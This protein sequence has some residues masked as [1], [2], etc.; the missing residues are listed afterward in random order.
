MPS[1][2]APRGGLRD[3]PT[4][5]AALLMREVTKT[6]DGARNA[7]DGITLQVPRGSFLA[8]TGPAG[9]GKSTLLHCASGLE[10]ATGGEVAIGGAAVRLGRAQPTALRHGRVGFVFRSYNLLPSLTVEEHLELALRVTGA[11]TDRRRLRR[12]ADRT[13]IGPLLDRRPERLSPIDQQRAAIARAFAPGPEIVFADEPTGELDAEAAEAVLA[14]LRDLV[15][16][17]GPAV[18]MATGRSEAAAFAHAAAVLEE[19]RIERFVP[20]PTTEALERRSPQPA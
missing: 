16:Q 10:A 18:V 17:S 15:E 14:L 9:S 7:L 12:L 8:V 6:Y 11:A 19:G 4:R 2:P 5:P 1:L 13:G 3:D 20:R